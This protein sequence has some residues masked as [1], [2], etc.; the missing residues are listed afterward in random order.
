MFKTIK[1]MLRPNNKQRTKLFQCAGVARFIYN[2]VLNYQ[3]DRHNAGLPFQNEREV[4]KLITKMKHEDETLR[5][6]NDYSNNIIKQAVK[7]AC[8]AFIKFF[9]HKANYPRYKS[10]KHSKPSFY[11]DTGKIQFT[12]SHVK[13]EKLTTSRKQN[14]QKFNW[15][16]LAEKNRVL[17]GVKYYSPRVTYDGI[18][19]WLTVGVDIEDRERGSPAR[20]GIG[21]D[22]GVKNLAVCSNKEVYGNINKTPKV[23]K[24]LKRQRRL[25][26]KISKK[27]LKNKKGES[28]CKTKNI[29][30]SEYRLLK[31]NHRLTNIRTDHMY[32]VITDIIRRE[33]SFITVEDLNIRGMLKN[34]HL[35]KAIQNQRLYTFYET[36]KFKCKENGIELRIV[37]RW[38]PSSKRCNHCGNIK[39]DLKLSD[40][41]Y[42]CNYCGYTVDRDYNASLNLRD[43]NKYKVV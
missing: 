16:R 4:R 17:I 26:R 10:R 14:R 11:I 6:L 3:T 19:W 1:I 23:I 21:I 42:H 37:D 15:I 32:R 22:L 40:R 34:R 35:S 29:E 31:L 8:D 18:N 24:L 33:P 7:D 28:Y 2:W 38:F 30:K 13:L 20:E 9:K 27:Y 41:V 5:W 25:Q 36:L 12:D 39:R 43:A